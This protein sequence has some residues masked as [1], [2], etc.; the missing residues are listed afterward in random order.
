V[1]RFATET[2]TCIS[3]AWLSTTLAAEADDDII[4]EKEADIITKRDASRH[5]D[6][7]TECILT[8]L[9]RL[10]PTPHTLTRFDIRQ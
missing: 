6:F 10:R 3:L 7:D 9:G 2:F 1:R 8:S 5:D 4:P